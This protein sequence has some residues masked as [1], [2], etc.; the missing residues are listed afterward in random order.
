MLVR[1][2]PLSSFIAAPVLGFIGATTIL[3]RGEVL[4]AMVM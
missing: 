3:T 1:T 4:A 2:L